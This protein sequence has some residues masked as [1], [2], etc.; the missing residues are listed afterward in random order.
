MEYETTE[1]V[2][3]LTIS[4][5]CETED[6]YTQNRARRLTFITCELTALVRL[7]PEQKTTSRLAFFMILSLESM[8]FY[9]F[10]L[11]SPFLHFNMPLK[12]NYNE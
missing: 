12:M 10:N 11:Y 9:G 8:L 6:I 4:N 5:V 2:R 7:S 1:F 3:V